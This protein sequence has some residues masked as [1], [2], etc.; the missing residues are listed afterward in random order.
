MHVD[1]V[2]IS[3]YKNRTGYNKLCF[4]RKVLFLYVNRHSTLLLIG[5]PYDGL[6][7]GRP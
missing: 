5:C 2:Q 1:S 3:A 7:I 6:E 4:E